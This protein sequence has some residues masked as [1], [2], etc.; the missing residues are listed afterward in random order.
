MQISVV[1][2]FYNRSELLRCSIPSVLAQTLPAH[3]IIVVDDCSTEDTSWVP[4]AFPAIQFIRLSQNGGGAAARYQ[5]ALAATGTHIAT[6]DMDDSWY[7]EKLERQAAFVEKTGD[8]RGVYSHLQWVEEGG[9]GSVRPQVLPRPDEPIGDYLFIRNGLIQSSTLLMKR[10]LYLEIS[11]YSEDQFLEDWELILE[12]DARHYRI[13]LQEEPLGHWNCASDPRRAS[14]V[15]KEQRYRELLQRQDQH[16]T[17]K[18]K[19]A[20]LGRILA[21]HLVQKGKYGVAVQLL[22]RSLA[23]GALSPI[24]VL[25]ITLCSLFPETYKRYAARYNSRQS[26]DRGTRDS[27]AQPGAVRN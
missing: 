6:L 21:P 26:K 4:Q 7:P 20:F 27:L 22:A 15:H 3:E 14:H 25:K 5:G 8:E 24:A 18:A 17:P 9:F 16:L 11:R 2:P 10:D 23:A 19:A 13:H 12:A 1:I